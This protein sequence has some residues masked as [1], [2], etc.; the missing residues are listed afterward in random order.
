MWEIHSA[1]TYIVFIVR[2]AA[3]FIAHGDKL[4]VYFYLNETVFLKSY[5]IQDFCTL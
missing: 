5:L 2:S 3:F 4:W 1:Y